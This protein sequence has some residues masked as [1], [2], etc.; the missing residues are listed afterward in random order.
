MR[1]HKIV[2]MI[3]LVLLALSLLI[4]MV[5][6]I[7]L[8]SDKV[9]EDSADLKS[10]RVLLVDTAEVYPSV[11]TLQAIRAMDAD[12]EEV[13]L[14]V[15]EPEQTTV[16]KIQALL[17]ANTEQKVVIVGVGSKARPAL[18]ASVSSENVAGVFLIAPQLRADDDLSMLGTH[19]PNFALGIIAPDGVL[20]RA[21]YERISGEDTRLFAGASSQGFISSQRYVSPDGRR[22]L[23]VMAVP[24]D[25]P[26]FRVLPGVS[27]ELSV[28]LGTFV[29]S[30]GER[31]QAGLAAVALY[32]STVLLSALAAVA[33]ILLF[34]SS[35][36]IGLR[37][38]VEEET[39]RPDAFLDD[40]TRTRYKK[41]LLVSTLLSSL[42]IAGISIVWMLIDRATAIY[43]LLLWPAFYYAN[44]TLLLPK[45]AQSLLDSSVRRERT[46]YAVIVFGCLLVTMISTIL[47]YQHSIIAVVHPIRAL[48]CVMI[49]IAIFVFVRR[50]MLGGVLFMPRENGAGAYDEGLRIPVIITRALLFL[51]GALALVG[52]F[53]ASDGQLVIRVLLL[54]AGIGFAILLRNIFKLIAGTAL[55]GALAMSAGIFLLLVF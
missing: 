21:L 45:R 41:K 25:I 14:P 39:V 40:V 23:S 19:R 9:T 49:S 48:F 7:L 20:V 26:F 2:R 28:F 38:D 55:F 51:P 34:V 46:R 42:I 47:S 35:I 44:A 22:V 13:I 16:T 4:S 31:S 18:L 37:R 33:G 6:W 53:V 32:R 1:L 36:P 29:M 5:P 12:Y 17:N 43:P 27:E 11:E 54:T 50:S 52:A 24:E 10:Y 8:A 30:D 3:G 15:S